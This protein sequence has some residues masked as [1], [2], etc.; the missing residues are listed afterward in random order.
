M[1]KTQ[2]M[3]YTRSKSDSERDDDAHGGDSGLWVDRRAASSDRDDPSSDS[4]S[5]GAQK[6]GPARLHRPRAVER[7]HHPVHA[8]LQAAG[9]HCH[10]VLTHT[11]LLSHFQC[12]HVL[13]RLPTMLSLTL[14]LLVQVLPSSLSHCLRRC[15]W[16]GLMWWSSGAVRGC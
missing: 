12:D 14:S 2:L 8:D 10:A 1:Q 6:W 4:D 7:Q 11:A 16:Q 13:A 3:S 9:A 5:R 15:C